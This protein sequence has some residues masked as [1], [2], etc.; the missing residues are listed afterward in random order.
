MARK[1]RFIIPGEPQHVIV[2][3]NN[4]S[5]IFHESKDYIFYLN[6]LNESILKNRCKLHAYVLMGNHVHLL[7]TPETVDGLGKTI[8]ML[9]R[10]YVQYFNFNY[11]RTGTL[12]EG[13]YKSALVDSDLYFLICQ[14]YIEQNPIRASIVKSAADYPWSS[15]HFNAMG[16]KDHMLTPHYEYKRLGNNA[17]EQQSAY[18]HIFRQN[19]DDPDLKAIREATNREWLLGSEQFKQ[20]VALHLNRNTVP[21]TQG[22]DRKSRHYKESINQATLTP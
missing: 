13:R 2:R 4:R 5:A 8:Q 18:R 16:K 12:W 22:G 9:G 6:K 21:S 7:I 15:Y 17:K 14:R 11:R 20:D 1:P 3:G 10:Y 19:I